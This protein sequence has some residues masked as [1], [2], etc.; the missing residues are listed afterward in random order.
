MKIKVKA[1]NGEEIK[2]NNVVKIEMVDIFD[3][4]IR[5]YYYN[6]SSTKAKIKKDYVK[7]KDITD[8]EVEELCC[9]KTKE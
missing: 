6:D 1:A 8:I 7:Y 2:Y 4:Y 5:I 3:S 9:T